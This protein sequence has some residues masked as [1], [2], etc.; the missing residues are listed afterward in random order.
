MAHNPPPTAHNAPQPEDVTQPAV[1]QAN[2]ELVVQTSA[3]ALMNPSADLLHAD[4]RDLI[5]MKDQPPRVLA[6]A[7]ATAEF[8]DSVVQAYEVL[9]TLVG[10]TVVANLRIGALAYRFTDK[11]RSEHYGDHLIAKF[12]I[13]LSAKGNIALKSSAVYMAKQMY[14]N[15]TSERC[16][17]AI[18]L[19]ITYRNLRCLAG[20]KVTED[21]QDEALAQV[22]AGDIKQSQIPDFIKEKLGVPQRRSKAVDPLAIMGEVPEA[23]DKLIAKMERF[24]ASAA[25]LFRGNEDAVTSATQALASAEERGQKAFKFWQDQL[26]IAKREQKKGD[27]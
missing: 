3:T 23:F 16:Q 2:A 8:D 22:A 25:K 26:K 14:C 12:L 13:A 9:T 19:Q 6:P 5:A 10:Q 1:E 27:A 15:L 7:E 20:N 24:G 21:L 4:M 11:R 17:K 18:D